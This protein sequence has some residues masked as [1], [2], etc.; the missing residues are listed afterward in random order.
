MF[1]LARR[2]LPTLKLKRRTWIYEFKIELNWIFIELIFI[3]F[4]LNNLVQF[5]AIW[6]DLCYDGPFFYCNLS[7]LLIEFTK[8]P[9]E[10]IPIFAV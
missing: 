5:G 3:D 7:F 10:A 1:Y 2:F 8:K 4:N 9:L 6:R